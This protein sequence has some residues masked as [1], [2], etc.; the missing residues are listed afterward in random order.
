M[1]KRRMTVMAAM[2]M[3]KVRREKMKEGG[4]SGM[5]MERRGKRMREERS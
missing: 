3:R 1:K 5:A 2:K 4:K